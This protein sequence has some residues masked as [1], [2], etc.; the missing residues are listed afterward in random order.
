ML[1]VGVGITTYGSAGVKLTEVL[2]RSIREKTEFDKD[3]TLLVLDDGTP[4]TRAVDEL[5]RISWVYDAEFEHHKSNAGI[6]KS[7][8]NCV[9]I[10]HDRFGCED[11]ILLNNDLLVLD[12]NWLKC[13]TYFLDNNDSVAMCGLPLINIDYETGKLMPYDPSSWGDKPSRVG[14]SVGCCFGLKYSVW[15]QIKNIDGSIG[16]WENLIAFHEELDF[17]FSC[18]KELGYDS[19]MLNYP[20]M[21]HY[22]GATFANYPELT[23]REFPE[24]YDRELYI[25]TI[26]KSKVYPEDWKK[27]G[28]IIWKDEKGREVVDRMAFSRFLFALKWNV[29]DNYDAPQIEVHR[30][31][32]DP[33][34]KREIKWL[35]KDC[36]EREAVV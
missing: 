34:P 21:G 24:G 7:W 9:K 6:P 13:L 15:R 19:W 22:G 18:A 1:E 11:I 10:L 16:F 20:P 25:K 12:K 17:G 23:V 26:M 8:N 28:R 2:L 36:N 30:R 27:A 31:V 5:A 32:I 35:D 3:F 4:D 33:L 29:L 14:C